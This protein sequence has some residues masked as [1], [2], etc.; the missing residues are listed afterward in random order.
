MSSRQS[1]R[2]V[3]SR[4][5][6]P[7]ADLAPF[8]AAY[9][10]GQW[11]LT[12]QPPHVTELI[13]DPCIHLVVE[14]GGPHAGAR[15]VGVWTRLWRRTLEGRGRVFGVK[16]RAGGIRAFT[17]SSASHYQNHIIPLEEALGGAAQ[18]EREVLSQHDDARAFE[19][20]ETWMRERR[21]PGT[22]ERIGLA[23]ALV[24]HIARSPEL[25]TVEQLATESGLGIRELQ[26]LF[27][28]YVGASP[29]WTLR[30]FRLQEVALRIERGEAPNLARLAAD[31]G[32]VDQAHLARDFKAAV[33]KSP[34]AF[35]AGVEG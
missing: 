18:L 19:A 8:V 27:R 31:L 13:G 32:Y 9:W 35:A 23:A 6:A 3:G 14:E 29:K 16:L 33:G 12:G 20:F 30:R 1:G 24:D 15:V 17:R 28:D 5:Y 25:L 7:S 2:R 4:T 10:T 34:S 22:D 21:L 26:R 11:D